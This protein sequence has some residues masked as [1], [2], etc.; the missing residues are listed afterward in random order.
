MERNVISERVTDAMKHKKAMGES[1]GTA[2]FGFQ[3]APDGVHLQHD[4]LEQHII[5]KIKELR[6]A[7]FSL[8]DIA[9]ELNK[10]EILTRSGGTWKYQ[11]IHNILKAAA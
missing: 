8:R 1:T 4:D 6:A 11:Y 10:Q 7:G 3:L 2:P 9:D 5:S